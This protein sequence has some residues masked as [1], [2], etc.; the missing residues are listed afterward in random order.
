[1][2]F[3]RPMPAM[4]SLLNTH[5]LVAA[6][7]ASQARSP[8]NLIKIPLKAFEIVLKAFERP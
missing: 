4:R 1:M 5:L 8:M 7:F 2:L 6:S 3:E